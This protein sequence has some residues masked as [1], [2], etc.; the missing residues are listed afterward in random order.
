MEKVF[1]FFNTVSK[2]T[3]VGPITPDMLPAPAQGALATWHR[4]LCF[5]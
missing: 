4:D 5:S 3:N 2:R 1:L